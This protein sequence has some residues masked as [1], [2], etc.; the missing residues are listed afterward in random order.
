MSQMVPV[1]L[2]DKVPLESLSSAA[3]TVRIHSDAV[4][5]AHL[6][7]ELVGVAAFQVSLIEERGQWEVVVRV[8]S[9]LRDAVEA[10]IQAV[11]RC[12]AAGLAAFASV[13]IGARPYARFERPQ[14]AA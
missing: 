1:G 11:R 4:G 6:M 9:D 13:H 12:L 10:V 14:T 3:N 8:S 5:A 2:A 7:R